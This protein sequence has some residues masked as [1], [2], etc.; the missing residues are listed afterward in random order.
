MDNIRTDLDAVLT[1]TVRGL[2][3]ARPPKLSVRVRQ[4]GRKG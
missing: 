4:P 1:D 3:L 2:G